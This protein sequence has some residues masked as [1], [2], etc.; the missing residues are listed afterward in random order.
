MDQ[1]RRKIGQ[2][3]L[4]VA[5]QVGDAYGAHEQVAL[6]DSRIANLRRVNNCVKTTLI[7]MFIDHEIS[8]CTESWYKLAKNARNRLGI[9][10]VPSIPRFIQSNGCSIVDFCGG[11]GGDLAKFVHCNAADVA[12]IDVS[13]KSLLEAMDRYNKMDRLPFALK[14][15]HADCTLPNLLQNARM[16][17]GYDIASCQ[18]ALHYAFSNA[19]SLDNLLANVSDSLRPGGV[20]IGTI[21]DGNKVV[22]RM[23]KANPLFPACPKDTVTSVGNSLYKLSFTLSGYPSIYRFGMRYYFQLQDAVNNI[24]E[25][26]VHFPTLI[27]FAAKH[28]L[29]LIP[30][31]TAPF[32]IFL[33]DAVNPSVASKMSI[34]NTTDGLKKTLSKDELEI[35]HLYMTFAFVKRLPCGQIASNTHVEHVANKVLCPADI[36]H[37]LV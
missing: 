5:R 35:V 16:D 1:K 3:P 19:A 30:E 21:L 7:T 31:A 22:K 9:A 29:A 8:E 37:L 2:D 33:R 32:K 36:I 25:Y 10:A 15:V 6:E 26:L 34:D 20:F 12:I 23:K 11:R 27:Q 17:H 24:P 28:G 13:E 18:F 14:L 4:H